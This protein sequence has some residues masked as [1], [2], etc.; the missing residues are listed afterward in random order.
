VA[1]GGNLSADE[2]LKQADMAMYEAKAS[3]RNTLRFFDTGIQELARRRGTLEAELRAGIERGQFLLYYQPQVAADGQIT[4]A[5]ALLRWQHPERG[6]LAPD[7]FL[8]LAEETRLILP[9]GN[10]VVKT[11][12]AQLAAWSRRPETNHLGLA[13][14]VATT[15]FQQPGFVE[16]LLQTLSAA[17]ANPRRLTLELTEATLLDDVTGTIVKMSTLKSEGI[18]FSLDNF[19]AG[20]SSLSRLKHLPLHKLKIDRS[21]VKEMLAGSGESSVAHIIVAL[22]KSLGLLVIAE[23]VENHSQRDLLNE[24]GCD[25]YQG[26]MFGHPMPLAEFE[27]LLGIPAAG[28]PP[29]LQIIR[30]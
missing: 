12:C 29:R 1:L 22:A 9:L 24:K 6:L 25:A 17:G 30:G 7:E 19:G 8:P 18:N 23:G 3:G 15:Q 11:A 16:H 4:G 10:W 2:L 5:E 26:F 21:L 14:N 27:A 28:S 13:V 20:Y